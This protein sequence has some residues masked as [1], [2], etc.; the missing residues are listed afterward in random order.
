MGSQMCIRD[1]CEEACPKEA[2]FLTDRIVPANLERD[3]FVFGKDRL[4][5]KLDDRI[6]ITKRQH[7]GKRSTI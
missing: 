3:E 7:T 4:V 1:R 6:D 5:E 2:I